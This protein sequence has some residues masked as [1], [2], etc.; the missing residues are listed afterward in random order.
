[1][2]QQRSFGMILLLS[3]ITCGIYFYYYL[4][5]IT[6][7]L[8]VMAQNDGEEQDPAFVILLY[9]LTCGI[10][11]FY[12]YYKQGNR[13]QRLGQHNSI[14]ITESGTTY[15][16]WLLLSSVTMGIGGVIGLFLFNKNFNLLASSYNTSCNAPY[17]A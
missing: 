3:I 10:F 5:V 13:M 16:I 1:M 7:D 11:I 4:Y 17:Q 2:I 12:W 6:R 8:N 14:D 9:F 15:L